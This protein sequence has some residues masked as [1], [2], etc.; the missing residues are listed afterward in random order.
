[1]KINKILVLVISLLLSTTAFS[2]SAWDWTD[3]SDGNKFESANSLAIDSVNQ[4]VY[5]AGAIDYA[6]AIYTD[7]LAAE[8][9]GGTG[10]GKLDGFVAKYD[11]NGNVIWSFNIGGI[12]AD[13]ITGITLDPTGKIYITGYIEGAAS[14]DGAVAGNP[15]ASVAIFGGEDIFVASYS[16]AGALIDYKVMGGVGRDMGIDICASSTQ[17]YV[18][19]S[20][21]N[22]ATFDGIPTMVPYITE[23][24]FIYSMD[25]ND[26]TLWLFDAGSDGDESNA[27]KKYY[28][29]NFGI[30]CDEDN[31]YLIGI[32]GGNTYNIYNSN[33]SPE[34][35]LINADINPD[36]V[37]LSVNNFGFYNWGQQIDNV[38]NIGGMGIAN[39]CAGLYITG[40]LSNLA[41]FPSGYIMSGND[42]G[43]IAGLDKTT[44]IDNWVVQID[45]TTVKDIGMAINTDGY[46]G[47]YVIGTYSSDTLIF[48]LDTILYATDPSDIFITKYTNT[49]VYEWAKN[50]NGGSNDYGVDI[51]IY[52]NEDVYVC[53]KSDYDLDLNPF[54]LTSL[55][56]D[57]LFVGRLP[58]T[59]TGS[60]MGDDASF[61]YPE[62]AYC[63]GW[64]DPVATNV[65]TAGG[66]FSASSLNVVFLDVL[67]GEIDLSASLPGTYDIYY[68]TSGVCPSKGSFTLSIKPDFPPTIT[69]PADITVSNDAGNC[70]AVVTYTTPVGADDCTIEPVVTQTDVTGLSS[71]STFPV[72]T[73]IQTY[74]V[75]D[76]SGLTATCSFNITVND[77]E[78]PV[79]NCVADQ[80]RNNTPGVCTYTV[81]GNEFD[82]TGTSD[83]CGV[84][85]AS[86]TNNYNGT[87]TI[88]GEV[89]TAG[90][91]DIR[92]YVTDIYGNTD[93]C[94]FEVKITVV[95]VNATVVDCGFNYTGETTIGGVNNGDNFSCSG[96]STPGEDNYYQITVP[97]GNHTI[98][99]TMDNVIDGN[100]TEAH[101]FWVG[102]ACP[103]GASCISGTTFDIAT[104]E[105]PN[106][107]NQIVYQAPGPGTYYLVVDAES[108]G[109]NLYDIAFDC[110]QSGVEFDISGG[111]TGDIDNDGV[112][113]LVNGSTILEVEQC[114]TVTICD[115]LLIQNLYGF[116]WLDSVHYDLG[117]CYTNITNITPNGINTGFYVT[118]DWNATYNVGDNSITWDFVQLGPP[119]TWGDGHDEEY[120]CAVNLTHEY[121]FCFDA[122]ISST[123]TTNSDLDITIV[124]SD[125]A[126]NGTSISTISGIA[127]TLIDDY[128]INDPAPT[129]NLCPTDITVNNDAGVC[130]AVVSWVAPVA[131]DNCPIVTTQTAGPAIGSLFPVGTTT[132]TYSATD[133]YSQTITC[134]FNVTVIDIENPTITC[135][136]PQARDTDS[137]V[138]TYTVVGT[139]FDN[140]TEGDNCAFTVT[141]NING[142][143]TLASEVLN[144]GVTNVVW[145]ILDANGLFSTCNLNITVS[146][147][148]SPNIT[149]SANQTIFANV[150]CQA[151]VP[152]LVGL[153]TAT[154]NCT[155]SGS[156]TITQA[157]LAGSVIGIGTTTVTLSVSDVAGNTATCTTDIIVEDNTDPVITVCPPDQTHSAN[158]SCQI[159]LPDLT[160]GVT[161]TD[162]CTVSG[163]LVITQ[164]P[165]AG[166]LIGIGT[167]PVTITVADESGNTA[168]C[169]T[170]II[171][172]DNTSPIITVCAPNQTIF[173]DA[174]CQSTVPD[175][176]GSITATDNCTASGSLVITQSPLAGSIIGIGITTITITVEDAAT[177]QTTCT[178]DITV[179]DNTD[180]IITAC[181]LDQTL[182]GD[183]NCQALVP[184]LTGSITATDNCTASGSLVITQSPL[185][186]TA[187]GIGTTTVTITVED[188]A[189]N[190]TTCTADITV[191]DNTAPTISCV[192][193]QNE[194]T[195]L[196]DCSYTTVGTEFDPSATNDNCGIASV[197]NNINGLTSLAGYA[198]PT[199]L[200]NVVWT[201]TDNALNTNT[202]SFN[203]NVIDDENPSIT[204]ATNQT[205]NTDPSVCTYT[206]IGSNSL[207]PITG[208]NCGVASLV[209][210]YNGTNS[211]SGA[212]FNLSTTIVNWTVTDVNGLTSQ[213]SHTITVEDN[214]DPGISC[215]G[216]QTFS[217][218]PGDCSYTITNTG[219]DAVPSDNCGVL[220]ILNDFDTS[221]SLFNEVFPL[222]T[223]TVVWTVTDNS[224]N[225]NT[226]SFNVT[227]E[228]NENPTLSCVSNQNENTD[229][230]DCTYTAVGNEFDPISPDDNCGILSITNNIN[231]GSSLAG[232]AFSLPTTNVIW[233][234]NDVNGNTNTC[235]FDVNVFDTEDPTISCVSNQTFNTD[236][237]LCSYTNSSIGS[238]DP[239]TGDNCGISSITNSFNGSDTLDGATFNTG[240]TIINWTI[241]DINGNSSTC[242]HTVTVN[243]SE[244]PL[245][246]CPSDQTFSADPGTCSYTITNNALNAIATDNCG[247]SSNT[248]NIST[249]S[250]LVGWSF[251][252][253][254]TNVEWTANDINGNQS[255][256]N[257]NITVEDNEDPIISTCAS[258]QTLFADV[259]CE[260]I[261][262]DLT[263][264]I[265][266][267]DNCTP[268]SSLSITQN[269]IAGSTIG[270]G[271]AIITITVTDTSGNF[272]NC[273]ADIIVEDNT[274][275]LIT[276]CA[277]DQTISADANCE[278]IV[279]D[280]TMGISANDNCT[281]NA[282]LV[283][284]QSPLAGTTI[285]LGI[286]TVTITVEDIAGN[287]DTC[288]AVITVEDNE[289]PIIGC[290]LDQIVAA[291]LDSCSYTVLG[292]EFQPSLI[293]DNCGIDSIYNSLNIDST[294]VGE[295]ISVGTTFI[296][297]YIVDQS[298]NIDSCSFNVIVEDTQAPFIS[299][300]PDQF[301][302]TDPGV[303]TFTVI[304]SMLAP[305]TLIDNCTLGST[306]NDFTNTGTLDGAILPLGTTTITWTVSD[307]AGNTDS[308]S[309]YVTVSDNENPEIVC[310]SS[311]TVDSDFGVCTYT[312]IGNEFEPDTTYDNCGV[313]SIYNTFNS[314]STLNG[315]VLPSGPNDI[316]WYVVDF[317][318]NIDSCTFTITVQDTVPPEITCVSNQLFNTDS[319]ACSYTI[320][321][322]ALNPFP[323]TD[324]CGIDSL[325]NNINGDTTLNGFA[326]NTGT[327]QV[328]WYAID[329]AG[330]IDSCSYSI[331]V[332]DIELPIIS[333]VA[334]QAVSTDTASCTYTV[335]G[336]EFDP[337]TTNDNCGISSVLNNIN[338][339]STL[340]GEILNIGVTNITWTITDINGNFDTCSF[341]I[342]VSD[343]EWPTIDAVSDIITCDSIVTYTLPI[344]SD[345]CSASL[346]QTDGTGLSSGSIFP[347][348]IT[349]LKYKVE[350]VANNSDSTSFDITVL[351]LPNPSWGISNSKI[352]ETDA[353]INLNNLIN[354]DS[355]GT[356]A[357][358]GVS[359]STFNPTS[360]GIGNHNI[361]YTVDNGVCFG[362][363]SINI[364][365]LSQPTAIAGA[366]SAVCGLECQLNATYFSG[367]S[368]W[369]NPVSFIFN[370]DSS[371]NNTII[372]APDY[373]VYTLTWDINNDSICFDSDDVEIT[374][375]KPPENTDAGNDQVLDYIFETNLE[376]NTPAEGYG[377]WTIV[378]GNANINDIYNPETFIS[379]LSYGTTVL[380]WTIENGACSDYDDVSISIGD[381]KIPNGF[382]PNDDG[383][384]DFFEIP[385]IDS[386]QNKVSVFNRWG[387]LIFEM[388]QYNNTWDGKNNNGKLL[389]DDT[390]FYVI[391]LNG[392]TYNGYIMINR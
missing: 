17:V 161:A 255:L 72:G 220:S 286:T 158:A 51:G 253:G 39:D 147:N 211:L 100:N 5:I 34:A 56:K 95:D 341:V 309:F 274:D 66:T 369:I 377:E 11:F 305:D 191:D 138:C 70:S 281:P 276:V 266:A 170:N 251:S 194:N 260:A 49:G 233:T 187:I 27:L 99:V 65:I 171:V 353:S 143:S 129:F 223:T 151:F 62:T 102:S 145:T 200:T 367:N 103:V 15:G 45:G 280:L 88:A 113:P 273:T 29:E 57:N 213:C 352:C 345:N 148:E 288:T 86:I 210:D 207:D 177:N 94:E 234:I 186:G 283:I 30:T 48:G 331:N 230:G 304:G 91:Y 343:N 112:I 208:D 13:E 358:A 311:Q 362:D 40:L 310:V 46:G 76:T 92:W 321:S 324:N 302:N 192:I 107:S 68:L 14:F 142:T 209:N 248:N 326:F 101:I 375:Y 236:I 123:C 337:D 23:N 329:F 20:Y 307:V 374:F 391:E 116:E 263:T 243:D 157:P 297:W 279:P 106:G 202:C 59:P 313:D 252:V 21:S 121:E 364:E 219:L 1:M 388:E 108:I 235:S 162:N 386:Y 299:C 232:V 50:C 122:D 354:G 306:T 290:L 149:C 315:A 229:F 294:L 153:T 136:G 256:C 241:T 197:T 98:V 292:N 105:F 85:L 79:I 179:E 114:E 355:G 144:I 222:G 89:M 312:V 111:C 203:V 55:E 287:S 26:N 60:I 193:N 327:T 373:G 368:N 212:T 164:S 356:W 201:I 163:S 124:I 204:C 84:N 370:P 301:F 32:L 271:T 314:D 10:G 296:T 249:T 242:S 180:P 254:T 198:F 36:I 3:G 37:I 188:G 389:P 184:D 267:T 227:V 291:D 205:F 47:V 81:I 246:T 43:F 110:I 137:G 117:I 328:T 119:T 168:T 275:P 134:T 239:I 245:V 77:K 392:K 109:I 261:V 348:G 318:G 127:V 175:L 244:F 4:F 320:T 265:S 176:T 196:G 289:N 73:T 258:N 300:L 8:M 225:T 380:K 61:D 379:E 330:N 381:L 316:T 382:S 340:D 42:D 363:S 390:Y 384:N 226:C 264:G 317:Y 167:T 156:M 272:T 217:T 126:L 247:I 344:Y 130:G 376:A 319:G 67:T 342:L 284:T 165:V 303:C 339:T 64:S 172:E 383:F 268:I 240:T 262:P 78:N 93:S 285:G 54:S 2:Q 293:S 7:I 58:I 183:I 334:N 214:E 87:N 278:A 178:A 351:A 349:T 360:A 228:D 173:A 215:V 83:N 277:L 133:T 63:Q 361:T 159:Q 357:G 270:L 237:G 325:Y 169:I 346:V 152:N 259:N 231:G 24:I 185:A 52:K 120:S 33:G 216:N 75:T 132:I 221:P 322:A 139:E 141:N 160:T 44:G 387:K 238:L 97:A 385:G 31:V 371:K 166:S 282:S 332:S 218:D 308:C 366:D 372:T 80:A 18:T 333:C 128:V 350:D 338:G 378:S 25:F 131:V 16:P 38:G 323:V 269:P 6:P 224:S 71:G 35:P 295:N 298:G 104:Q 135:V 359:A 9:N 12:N 190:Q 19:G 96:V 189:T 365:V 336:S 41:S 125:D 74:T 250:T 182:S 146:D 150:I 118:G 28:E 115:T 82:Y 206:H 335:I 195:D 140:L 53:G 181:A 174:S 199:G 69:C 90:T 22:A 154:D 257:M 347:I 155:A